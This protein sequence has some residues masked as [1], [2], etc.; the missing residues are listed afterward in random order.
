MDKISWQT[1]ISLVELM[2][3][4]LLS[5]WL[6]VGIVLAYFSNQ[7]SYLTAEALAHMQ[8]NARVAIYLLSQEVH[9]A[10]YIGC[11]PLNAIELNQVNTHFFSDT[12]LGGWNQGTSTFHFHLP[13][14]IA[15]KAAPNTNILLVQRMTND[16]Y[17]VRSAEKNAIFFEQKPN[18]EVGETLLISDCVHA[19]IVQVTSISSNKITVSPALVQS[20][21]RASQIG[22]LASVFYYI[23]KTNRKNTGGAPIYALYRRDINESAKLAQEVVEGIENMQIKFGIKQADKVFYLPIQ[24]ITAADW[25]AIVSV[26]I[27]LLLNSIDPILDRSPTYQFNQKNDTASDRL[28]RREWNFTIAVREPIR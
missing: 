28:L 17:V 19:N 15:K 10:G 11:L 6:I 1:G 18:Y 22:H 9:S 13:A 21:N 25:Q 3:A 2:I 23:R 26:Q 16:N 20:Y 12:R 27:A 14:D 4:M 5:L 8:E 7:R 24:Q